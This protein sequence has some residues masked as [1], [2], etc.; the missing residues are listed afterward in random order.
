M[1][2]N[3]KYAKRLKY[4]ALVLLIIGTSYIRAK[5]AATPTGATLLWNKDLT[6]IGCPAP[7][8]ASQFQSTRFAIFA[9]EGRIVVASAGPPQ[10]SN[11]GQIVTPTCL[12][13]FESASGKLVAKQTSEAPRFLL[14]STADGRVILVTKKAVLLNSDL[15]DTGVSFDYPSGRIQHVSPDGTTL[16]WERRAKD[17]PGMRMLDTKTLQPTGVDLSER[18][19]STITSKYAASTNAIWDKMDQSH[20]R[21]SITTQ[22]GSKP[23]FLPNCAKAFSVNFLTDEKMLITCTDSFQVQDLQGHVISEQSFPGKEVRYGGVS[24]NGKRFV[25][26]I[27]KRSKSDPWPTSDEEHLVYDLDRKDVVATVPVQHSSDGTWSAISPNGDLLLI[28][29]SDGVFVYEMH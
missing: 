19:P 27:E 24:R 23:L 21:G 28:G 18:T 16:A 13:A 10:K 3:G 9:D 7:E 6:A 17:E 12:L 8:V 1:E 4:A 25:M 14:F 26:V 15:S 2:M 11:E 22:E 20:R 29:S 5:P